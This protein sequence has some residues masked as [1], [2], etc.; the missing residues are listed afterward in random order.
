[1]IYGFGLDYGVSLDHEDFS[2]MPYGVAHPNIVYRFASKYGVTYLSIVY[3]FGLDHEEFSSILYTLVYTALP[4]DLV[5]VPPLG[6]LMS[7]SI[8]YTSYPL[9]GYVLYNEYI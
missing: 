5:R 9:A 4:R 6:H 3:G 2:S 7:S 8:D 1:M